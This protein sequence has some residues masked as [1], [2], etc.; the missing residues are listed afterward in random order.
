MKC[1]ECLKVIEEYFDGELNERTASRMGEHLVKCESCARSLEALKDEQNLYALYRRDAEPSPAL[2]TGVAARIR[3][4]RAPANSPQAVGW[5]GRLAELFGT[6]RLSPA[7]TF[8]LLILAV[9][10][11][12]GL[13]KYLQSRQHIVSQPVAQKQPGTSAPARPQPG[14][15]PAVNP[16]DKESA[17]VVDDNEQLVRQDEKNERGEEKVAAPYRVVDKVES[18][19]AVARTVG[20]TDEVSPD[21]LV[22]E[23]EQKYRA[24][25]ALL[26][27]DAKRRR[28][29]LE[30][31]MLARF[32]QTLAAV[33][34]TISETRRAARQ[35]PDDPVAVQYM[36]AAYAK[37]VEVLREMAAYRTYDRGVQ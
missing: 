4:E 17:A 33:D 37:K 24:A 36:L 13:M 8:A 28:T 7:L 1:E 26:A 34:R 22:R 9:G 10:A 14:E 18:K 11:T 25:I 20:F 30:P 27:R 3:Q 5:R 23:A 16:N 15:S 19:R 32:D 12:A 6:P 29:L 35:Q 2:W 21:Q 31:D